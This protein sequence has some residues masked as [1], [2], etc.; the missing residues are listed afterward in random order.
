MRQKSIIRREKMAETS[1]ETKL[2]HKAPKRERRA[3]YYYDFGNSAYAAVVL[4]AVYVSYFKDTVVGQG[5]EGTRLW[6]IAV[7]IAM[8]VTVITTPILGAIA[9]F[10][11][12]KK[13]FLLF[14]TSIVVIFTAMLFFVTKGNIFIGM[15]FFILAEIGYRDSQVFYDALL[16]DIAYPEEMG[17]VSGNG[18]A[19]GSVGG[20]LCLVVVLAAILLVPADVLAGWLSVPIEQLPPNLVVRLSFVFTALF[21]AASSVP[22]FLHL[23][24]RTE[25]QQLPPGENYLSIALKRLGETFRSV[26]NYKNFIRFVIS[27][28]IFNDGII[29]VLN[30]AAIIGLVLYGLEQQALLIFMIIVQVTSV[31]GAWLMGIVADRMGGKRSL[32]FSLFM[33]IITVAAL[34]V[35]KSELAFYL[36]GASA[37]FALTGVQSVSRMMVAQLA[38]EGKAAEFYGFFSIAGRTSSFIGPTIFGLVAA[39][40]TNRYI[41]QGQAALPAE[42]NGLYIALLTV[43][44]FLIVG[45]ILFTVLVKDPLR[46]HRIENRAARKA[47]KSSLS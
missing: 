8:L 21:F 29:M 13:L 38:P 44:A 15:L 47:A 28:L 10:T 35:F 40:A 4:L 43:I 33:M 27:F 32:L 45:T 16:P 1:V 23:K 31:A 42:Q 11:G 24:E 25:P 17:I 18:W 26:K 30:F 9:D 12:K 37:G 5:A 34:Y 7:G 3:W 14:Y 46:K 41:A 22:I 36:I 6:G 39:W 19:I 2:V 20:I